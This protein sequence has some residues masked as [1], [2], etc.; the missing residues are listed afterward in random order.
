VVGIIYLMGALFSYLSSSSTI[1]SVMSFMSSSYIASFSSALSS[2]N[3][4]KNRK[5]YLVR[6]QL[7]P[8]VIIRGIK[9]KLKLPIEKKL[10]KVG[11]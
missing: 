2:Y 4:T 5:T 9:K 3:D 11:F 7:K 1:K 8:T 10:K 6:N